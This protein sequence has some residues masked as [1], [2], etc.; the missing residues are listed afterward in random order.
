MKK[1]SF[2]PSLLSPWMNVY[3]IS[4]HK[5]LCGEE[6]GLWFFW[7]EVLGGVV[8]SFYLFVCFFEEEE[9]EWM[10][11]YIEWGEDIYVCYVCGTYALRW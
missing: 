1:I 5:K 7:E 9:E 6:I 10:M 11:V 4:K 3:N 8:L 2:P